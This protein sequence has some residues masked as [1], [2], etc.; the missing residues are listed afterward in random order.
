M[1]PLPSQP[2]SPEHPH[3]VRPIHPAH[4]SAHPHHHVVPI[5]SGYRLVVRIA[6]W[7]VAGAVLVGLCAWWVLT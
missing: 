4:H 5:D 3:P 7:V 6:L 2:D 1:D